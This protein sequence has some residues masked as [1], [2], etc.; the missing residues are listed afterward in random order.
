MR[1]F[2][3]LGLVISTGA[4]AHDPARATYLGNEGVLV[5]RGGTKVLF[6]AFYDDSYGEYLTIAP[7]TRNAMMKGAP[8]Y[9]GVDAVFVSHIHGDHFSPAPTIA[10]LRAQS[11]VV[12]YAPAQA[13]RAI[14]AAGVADD[15]PIIARIRAIDMSPEDKAKSFS[16]GAIEIEVVSILHAGDRK[17]V[18]N[19]SWRVTLDDKTTVIHF[20]DAGAVAA[21]FE[22]HK[23]HFAARRHDA[24]FPPFW[25]YTEDAG[26]AILKDVIKA[27]QTIG[28]H[29]PASAQGKGEET[30][31]D[32]GGDLFT[33]PGET[34]EIE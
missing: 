18:Q 20:G 25:W 10:Y 33:D 29:V 32:L 3:V 12:L 8:P 27:K 15:D 13:K 23:A 2:L 24:A 7:E 28:V 19:Y 14:L 16:V 11:D 31:R 21:N 26:R 30:R 1:F 17:D 34:R 22:R 5:A 6:D 4:H 9:D